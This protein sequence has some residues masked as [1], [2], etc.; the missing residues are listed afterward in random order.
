[1]KTEDRIEKD[2]EKWL[3]E[4]PWMESW[5]FDL[6]KEGYITGATAERN[7]TIDEAINAMKLK[8]F[9][10]ED[11]NGDIAIKVLESLKT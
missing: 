5:K 8:G 2:A 9:S 4:L 3:K 7:K 6:V 1:M 10:P 11:Y